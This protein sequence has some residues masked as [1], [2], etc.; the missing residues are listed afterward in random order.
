M[1]NT[2]QESETSS[3]SGRQ[4]EKQ[5]DTDTQIDRQI[6]SDTTQRGTGR[7]GSSSSTNNTG[8]KEANPAGVAGEQV[9]SG[10]SAITPAD[11][12]LSLIHI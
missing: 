3:L 2:E 10:K 7:A 1:N 9:S 4:I 5:I 8:N 6:Q 11:N 12:N